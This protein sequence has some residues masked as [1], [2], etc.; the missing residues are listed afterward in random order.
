MKTI[1]DP[2]LV[3]ALESDPVC[4]RRRRRPQAQGLEAA[5]PTGCQRNQDSAAEVPGHRH[6]Q[7]PRT[8]GGHAEI[9]GGDGQSGRLEVR[10]PGRHSANDRFKEHLKCRN[11]SARTDSW[12]FSGPT[13]ARSTSRTSGRKRRSGWRRRCAGGQGSE[14]SE[15]PRPDCPGQ[16]READRGRRS[17]DRPDL[18]EVRRARDPGHDSRHRS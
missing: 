8:P 15:G 1:S 2:F 17:A 12:S 14:D 13:G 9:P 5:Q 10:Q 11:R 4:S 7:P 18:G 3:C 6:A 16:E